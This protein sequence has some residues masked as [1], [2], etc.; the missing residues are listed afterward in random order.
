MVVGRQDQKIGWEQRFVW[1]NRKPVAHARWFIKGFEKK[2]SE[3]VDGRV[4]IVVE[5]VGGYIGGNEQPAVNL[6]NKLMKK[7]NGTA[8]CVPGALPSTLHHLPLLLHSRT[9]SRHSPWLGLHDVEP[10]GAG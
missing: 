10:H 1:P 4:D 9:E 3:R 5:V 8:A 2:V 6:I 7:K